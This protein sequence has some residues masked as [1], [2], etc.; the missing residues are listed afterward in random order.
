MGPGGQADDFI[1]TRHFTG[2]WDQVDQ[3][4]Q[5]ILLEVIEQ[6]DDS[7]RA[8]AYWYTYGSD[9][10]SAW[11][12]GIGDLVENRI[13]FELFES[14][15]V[16]FME[17]T[18]PDPDSVQSIGTLS[19]EF[20]SCDFGNVTFATSHEEVGSGSF[21]ITRVS[22]V[23]NTHCSGGISDDMHSDASVGEQYMELSSAREGI[24]G[25]GRARYES[26]PGHM[27]FEVEVEDLPDGAYHLFTG[28]QQRG[29]FSVL[30][31]RGEIK[32]RSPGETGTLMMTFDP[33]G[34][35]IEVHDSTG[36]ILSSFENRF[37]EDE[38]GHYGEAGHGYNYDCDRMPGM[39]GGMHG[40]MLD[41]VDEG[42]FIEIEVELVN[43]AVL[44]DAEGEAEWKM[45]SDHVEFSV[46][47]EDVPAG[48]YVLHAGGNE[49]GRF[50]AFERRFGD[51]Y[52]HIRFRDPA[53]YGR[54]PLDFEPRGQ[55]IEVLKE[56]AVILEV[57]FPGS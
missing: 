6:T 36:V 9:R 34:M 25:S 50:E 30:E 31:G 24:E 17:P 26:Y 10:K 52:G 21:D 44:A 28:M 47:I 56:G 41:C 23:M 35:Q 55:K 32:F 33:R 18:R 46:E 42:D 3:E 27:E 48:T 2:A 38:H 7:R 40:G 57:D 22:E 12:L 1:V 37:D 13:E 11:Y 39:G 8:V 45:T 49:V 53:S 29:E 20:E 54:Q 51:V 43:T 16:G 14:A 5:G 15:D 19:I 4:S